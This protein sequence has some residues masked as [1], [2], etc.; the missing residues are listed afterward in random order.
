[1]R[2]LICGSWNQWGPTS[3]AK[4]ILLLVS[5]IPKYLSLH[6]R[7]LLYVSEREKL[8]MYSPFTY[9]SLQGVPKYYYLLCFV[10]DN[11]IAAQN[12]NGTDTVLAKCIQ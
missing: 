3:E 7:L 2:L 10:L 12:Y 4:V 9:L 11:T 1:M 8:V 5:V 6:W